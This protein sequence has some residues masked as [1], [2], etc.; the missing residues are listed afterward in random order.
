ML[1]YSDSGEGDCVVWIMWDTW[2]VLAQQDQNNLRVS[3]YLL[4]YSMYLILLFFYLVFCIIWFIHFITWRYFPI[5]TAMFCILSVKPTPRLLTHQKYY[6]QYVSYAIFTMLHLLV[7]VSFLSTSISND[8][9]QHLRLFKHKYCWESN[10][11]L[12]PNKEDTERLVRHVFVWWRCLCQLCRHPPLLPSVV[13]LWQTSIVRR[14]NR[15]TGRGPSLG[16]EHIQII[17]T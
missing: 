8:F 10:V 7:C 6:F 1:V 9:H 15:P 16:F 4:F 12:S 13:Q 5:E 11:A 3:L 2:Q 17:S 14:K